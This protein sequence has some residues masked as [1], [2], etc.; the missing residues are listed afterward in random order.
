MTTTMTD[1][2]VV[3][4]DG[5]PSSLI[6]TDLAAEEARLRGVALSVVHVLSPPPAAPV[7]PGAP[8][9]TATA[10]AGT[11]PAP[12]GARAGPGT[13]PPGAAA[14]RDRA[15][16]LVAE[17]VSRV[18]ALAPEVAVSGEVVAGETLPV[19]VEHS[20]TAALVVVGG[21]G[22]GGFTELLLGSVAEHLAAHAHCPLLVSR[23]GLQPPP[24]PVVLG[25]DGSPSGSGA[26]GFAFGQASLHGCGLV[27]AHMWSEWT[28]P[29][30]AP[31]KRSMPFTYE[32]DML[33]E[34]EERLLAEALA[35]WRERFPDVGVEHRVLRGRTR[36]GLIEASKEARLLVVGRRGRGGFAGMLLGSVSHAALHHAHCPVVVVPQ[37]ERRG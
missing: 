10:T 36:E 12:E 30:S 28:A 17:A 7:G 29:L 2:V 22:T 18:R 21:R 15:E 24:G 11:A 8:A 23:G 5:S 34:G 4:V 33:R 16:K 13:L 9:A 19:L 20:R 37:G 35:G 27:A 1:G 6:A 3:G 32:P 31:E 26:T 25:V 14:P